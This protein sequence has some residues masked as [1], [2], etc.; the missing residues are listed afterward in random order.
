MALIQ[1]VDC[2]RGISDTAP[3]CPG[4][5]RPNQGG[6]QY[7]IAQ[8]YA[9]ELIV[10]DRPQYTKA[11]IWP[12]VVAAIVDSVI[13]YGIGLLGVMLLVGGLDAGSGGAK[14]L[15]AA[16][17][18]WSLWYGF[19]KDGLGGGA[20]F[21]K[22]SQGLMV[23]HLPSNSACSKSKSGVRQLVALVLTAFGG[24]GLV[25]EVAIALLSENGRRL[26]D[27]AADTQVVSVE[28]FRARP[29]PVRPRTHR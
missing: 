21:G 8:S 14:T 4:C 6:L 26:G 28:D 5:G 11:P 3:S 7:A 2:G 9:A 12:R 22:R 23:V 18:V 16:L 25:V 20:G 13:G 24:I 10:N 29:R 1:C 15:G 27:R 17:L 19:A